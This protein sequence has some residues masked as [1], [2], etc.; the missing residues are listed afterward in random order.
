MT[1]WALATVIHFYTSLSRTWSR[2]RAVPPTSA[3][4]GKLFFSAWG[5]GAEISCRE[6]AT[7]IHFYLLVQDMERE[8]SGPAHLSH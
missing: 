4:S 3:I 2:R 7:V 5:N 1:C 6:L 8:E